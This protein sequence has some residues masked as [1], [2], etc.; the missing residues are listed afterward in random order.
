MYNQFKVNKIYKF[1][2]AP[3]SAYFKDLKYSGKY[4]IVTEIRKP[5]ES[6]HFRILDN[7]VIDYHYPSSMTANLDEDFN[8]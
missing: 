7:G 2:D 1:A 3:T 5:D 6:V 4:F 8:D